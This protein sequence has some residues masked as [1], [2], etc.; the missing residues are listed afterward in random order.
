[1][2]EELVVASNGTVHQAGADRDLTDDLRKVAE[3]NFYAFCV[4]IRRDV[5]GDGGGRAD[6]NSP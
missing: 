1:M 5:E 3:R 6:W 2:N 4:G